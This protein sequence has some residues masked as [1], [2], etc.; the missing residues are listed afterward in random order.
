VPASNIING[1]FVQGINGHEVNVL[2]AKEAKEREF[3]EA[4][5]FRAFAKQS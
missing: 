3:M 5:E 2:L 1:A 4:S